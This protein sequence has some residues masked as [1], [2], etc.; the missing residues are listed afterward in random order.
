LIS[1][2]VALLDKVTIKDA[3]VVSSTEMNVEQTLTVSGASNFL[4][5]VFIDGSLTGI[6]MHEFIYVLY[7]FF[8]ES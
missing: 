6:V 4:G 2:L 1:N 5:E 8:F 7:L 3:K